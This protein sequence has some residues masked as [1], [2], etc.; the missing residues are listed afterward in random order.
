[1]LRTV[2]L[3]ISACLGGGS[4]A[5]LTAPTLSGFLHNLLFTP[6]YAN[7][8]FKECY[9]RFT[10]VDALALGVSESKI[11]EFAR[12]E[13]D[14]ALWNAVSLIRQMDAAPDEATRDMLGVRLTQ[15][16]EFF[17]LCASDDQWKTI[18]SIEAVDRLRSD[19]RALCPLFQSR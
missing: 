19:E 11:Q 4:S 10:G 17:R 15:Q 13:A 14:K 16:M 8:T 9:I 3:D 1:M 6:A 18:L 12:Q 2:G 7:E 5:S